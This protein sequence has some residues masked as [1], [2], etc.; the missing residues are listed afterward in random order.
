MTQPTEQGREI[1]LVGS[2][3][4]S[5]TDEVFH[6]AATILGDRIR[7]IPDGET[8][9]R[10][11]W[12]NFQYTVLASNPALDFAG[13]PID[14]EALTQE[15]DGQGA[16]YTF[17]RLRLRE[18]AAASE[19]QLSEL[20]YAEHALRSYERFAELKRAGAI[21]PDVR[22]QVSLPTP[23][24]PV[25][26]FV[27]PENIFAVYQPY[28]RALQAELEAVL[29]RIPH[30]QLAVQWD[31]AVEIALW[32]GV[33]PRPPGDW[34]QMLLGQLS[35]L[36]ALVPATVPFGYH[37]C[38]GDRGHKHFVEPADT[39]NLTEIA[40]GLA[41]RAARPI[42]WIHLPVPRGRDDD[43]YFAP[44]AGLKL[45]PRTKLFLGLVHYTDGVEGARRRLA[46]AE[47][48]VGDFGI[49]TECGLGRRNPATILELLRIHAAI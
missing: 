41:E 8:G 15:K 5:S 7:K 43:A 24:A 25:A 44:L 14:L 16:D 39:A 30:D 21:G 35:R 36:S 34:K 37:L 13:P 26:V 6:A 22:F 40:N 33:F 19:I 45:H 18:G 3:P 12:I 23:L 11:N 1:H 29:A 2:V 31:V 17:T 49:G 28:A 27:V 4:L 47:K 32:E 20:G 9:R 48:V 10:R 46:A 38:Y 42:D